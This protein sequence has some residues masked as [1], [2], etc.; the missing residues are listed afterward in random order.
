MKTLDELGPAKLLGPEQE[1]IRHAADTLIFA[2]NALD[3]VAAWEALIDIEGLCRGL[4][5]SGRW[6]L[7]TATHLAHQVAA[8][9]PREMTAEAA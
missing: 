5:E 3:D 6:E 7:A 4:V 1:R 2:T 9:G 8:C